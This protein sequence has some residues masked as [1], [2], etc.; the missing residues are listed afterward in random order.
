MVCSSWSYWA[1]SRPLF[2]CCS[3][4]AGGLCNLWSQVAEIAPEK[5]ELIA[6]PRLGRWILSAFFWSLFPTYLLEPP[7]IQRAL[8]ASDKRKVKST[9]CFTALLYL[10][11]LGLVMLL[12]LGLIAVRFDPN[13]AFLPGCA[14]V[15]EGTGMGEV[16]LLVVAV[17]AT[18][19][20]ADS[21]LNSL[22][23]GL[24]YDLIRP[25]SVD[26]KVAV[27]ELKWAK[28]LGLLIGLLAI[29]LALQGGLP[30]AP[31]G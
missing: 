20:T 26:Y 30:Y 14:N 1:A 12:G 2:R 19:S 10:A 22:L 8:M 3:T 4:R 25:L 29:L 13:A 11:F 5:V 7:I 9:M 6:H 15:I 24:V 23:A 16:L 18:M 28:G 21:F 17:A 27:D 31:R